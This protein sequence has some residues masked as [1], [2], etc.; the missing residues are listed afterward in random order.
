MKVG[1]KRLLI[2]PPALAIRCIKALNTSPA[3]RYAH[4]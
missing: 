2:I 4:L 3:E 1:G